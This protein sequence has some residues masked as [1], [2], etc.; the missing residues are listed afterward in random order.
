MRRQPQDFGGGGRLGG[1]RCR[2]APSKSE[3]P[4]REVQGGGE[5]EAL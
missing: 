1:S 2:V 4:A 5:M 3:M